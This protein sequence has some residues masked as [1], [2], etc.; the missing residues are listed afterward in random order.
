M[1][2]QVTANAISLGKRYRFDERHARHVAQLS[3]RLFDELRAEHG[4]DDRS[5]LMLEVSAIL[6]DIG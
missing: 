2:A 3:C 6:H 5:R 4:L 1:R